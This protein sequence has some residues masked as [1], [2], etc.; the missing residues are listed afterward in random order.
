[1]RAKFRG[2]SSKRIMDIP[3]GGFFVLNHTP[4]TGEVY[5]KC[6]THDPRVSAYC[7]LIINFETGVGRTIS[8]AYGPVFECKIVEIDSDG[9]AVFELVY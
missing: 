9:S 6:R 7:M 2:S 4:T 8:Q 1:M 3:F 5:Q